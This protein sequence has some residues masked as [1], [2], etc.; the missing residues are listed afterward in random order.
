MDHRP[1]L[2]VSKVGLRTK[3]RKYVCVEIKMGHKH[4]CKECLSR[5]KKTSAGKLAKSTG[6]GWGKSFW[7][8]YVFTY[9]DTA[10]CKIH[11]LHA[12][13]DSASRR[14]GLS[15]AAPIWR[16]KEHIKSIY[17]KCSEILN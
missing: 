8:E 14:A 17:S 3:P 9:E 2:A 7:P 4:V 5:F 6:I 15:K 13:L 11:H 16:D 12:A 1:K 10:K